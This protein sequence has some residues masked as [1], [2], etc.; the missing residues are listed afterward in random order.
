MKEALKQKLLWNEK[1]KNTTAKT[2]RNAE[3]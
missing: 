3:V 2:E 1:K